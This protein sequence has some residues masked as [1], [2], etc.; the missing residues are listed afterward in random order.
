MFNWIPDAVSP[1]E[2]NFTGMVTRPNE[3]VPEAKGRAVIAII[4]HWFA[5]SVHV[6][7]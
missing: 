4:Y 5:M 1:V 7:G 6:P 3:I 2:Y